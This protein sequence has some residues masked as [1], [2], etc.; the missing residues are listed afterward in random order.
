M[1][2]QR[3]L[4]RSKVGGIWS[5]LKRGGGGGGKAQSSDRSNTNRGK[6]QV[7]PRGTLRP[8][9]EEDDVITQR[10]NNLICSLQALKDMRQR[11]RR[12]QRRENHF[13]NARLKRRGNE[14]WYIF[15]LLL[16]TF[17]LIPHPLPFPPAASPSSRG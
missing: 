10:E 4:P 6:G 7:C 5:R 2:S 16:A 13:G 8:R 1:H 15:S 3:P 17:P 11:R 12:Q 14:E 9:K